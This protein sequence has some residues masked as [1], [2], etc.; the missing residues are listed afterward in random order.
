MREELLSLMDAVDFASGPSRHPGL[1]P[2]CRPPKANRTWVGFPLG[3]RL[4]RRRGRHNLHCHHWSLLELARSD[5]IRQFSLVCPST[6]GNCAMPKRSSIGKRRSKALP[7]LG[8]AGMSLSMASG[9]CASTSEAS[10]NTSPPSQKHEI[11]LGEEEISDVSLATFYVFDKENAGP[12]P[13]FQKLRLAAGC[14]AGCGCSFGCA[15][16][17][18]PPQP[19]KA[20]QP[21]QHRKKKPPHRTN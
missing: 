15:Y 18:Q 19:P 8:F 5:F 11:F 14:G 21:T 20:T 4:D 9:A 10:A 7:V 6:W 12:P 2:P 13:L 17:P 16:W 3:Q 1:Q